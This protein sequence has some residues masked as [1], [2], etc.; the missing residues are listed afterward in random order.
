MGLS[1]QLREERYQRC[2]FPSR[3]GWNKVSARRW[4]EQRA[5][6]KATRMKAYVVEHPGGPEVL[7][8]R[9]I[10]SPEPAA[11]EVQIRVRA[12]GLNRAE[13]YWRAGQM[14]AITE[15]RVPGLEAVGEVIHDP[16]GV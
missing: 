3:S 16:A 9:D 13:V 10:P 4:H 5:N 11:D 8:L 15:P 14:G 6:K 1:Y 2:V 12:F 7:Q